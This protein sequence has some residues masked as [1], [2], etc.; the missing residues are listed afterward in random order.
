M[1]PPSRR[2]LS[3]ASHRRLPPDGDLQGP[4]VRAPLSRSSMLPAHCV[5]KVPCL[6]P[7][8]MC[9]RTVSCATFAVHALLLAPPFCLPHSRTLPPLLWQDDDCIPTGSENNECRTTI[10]APLAD[11]HPPPLP[12]PVLPKPPSCNKLL[13]MLR[14]D[15][16]RGWHDGWRLP[17]A[18]P[19]P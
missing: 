13:T 16:C 2:R 12:S 19:V 6:R 9:Q 8:L 11:C 17:P 3:C 10:H 5:L 4:D 18:P 14:S 1:G 15:G 7:E